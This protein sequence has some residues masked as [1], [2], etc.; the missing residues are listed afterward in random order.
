[1]TLTIALAKITVKLA[2]SGFFLTSPPTTLYS[3][4][5]TTAVEFPRGSGRVPHNFVQETSNETR[6]DPRPCPSAY[7]GTRR[8][9]QYSGSFLYWWDISPGL[10]KDLDGFEAV[11]FVC[12]DTNIGCTVS[13]KELKKL[14]TPE[15]RTSRGR[16]HWGI[17]HSM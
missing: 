1:M 15:R 9:Q 10:A 4:V 8:R 5:T 13:V 11:E 7:P 6:R 12:E 17:S 16:G 14:L 2:C 3:T